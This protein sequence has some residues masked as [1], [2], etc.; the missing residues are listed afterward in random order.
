[1]DMMPPGIFPSQPNTSPNANP[2]GQ[3]S[4]YIGNQPMLG[5]GFGPMSQIGSN[6][7]QMGSNSTSV[8]YGNAVYHFYYQCWPQCLGLRKP[9]LC[10]G[11]ILIYFDIY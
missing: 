3:F 10:I 1:M 7:G 5:P 9:Y 2:M 4:P 11:M 8:A 6:I